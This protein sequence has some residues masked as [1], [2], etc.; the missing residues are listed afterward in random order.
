MVCRI[1][2][3]ACRT[4]C[5]RRRL[6]PESEWQLAEVPELRI[7]DRELWNAVKAGQDTQ[8]RRRSKVAT[9]NRNRLSSGQ[10]LRRR[11]YL[12]SGLL[13]CGLCGGRMA[14]A[15]SGQIQ[16]LLLRGGQGDRPKRSRG[17]PGPP[18]ERRP[19]HGTVGPAGR[20]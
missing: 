13:H 16:D 12:L 7:N 9:T 10:T 15:G 14:V 2:A 20:S 6:N 1:P 4:E 19:A 8:A 5:G 11:K 3:I 17:L 18:G